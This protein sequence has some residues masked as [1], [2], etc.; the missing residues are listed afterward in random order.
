MTTRGFAA[1]AI[2]ARAN[3]ELPAG[4][5]EKHFTIK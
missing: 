4:A 1:A 3:I 2:Y 5:A